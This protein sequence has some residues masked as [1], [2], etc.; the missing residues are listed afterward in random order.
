[1][2]SANTDIEIKLEEVRCA[3]CGQNK[4]ELI[5]K[6]YDYE[7]R[8]SDREFCFVRCLN[9]GHHYLNPR[10]VREAAGRIYPANYYTME[11][12]HSSKSKIIAN[13]KSFVIE[14]R[15]SHFK[16][17]F[18]RAINVLEVGCGDCSLIIALKKKFPHINCAGIDLKFP[19][20]ERFACK[21][22]GITLTEGA[23][24]DV[25][26][27]PGSYNLVILN[28][29]I[30]H[31]WQPVEVLQKLNKSMAQDGL[32]SIETVNFS[33]YDRLFFKKGFWGG[34]YFPRHLNL[35][36]FGTLETLLENA[37]FDVI[38]QNSLLAPVVWTFSFH[39]WV[40]HFKNKG[41]KLLAGFFK[42]SNPVCLG[43]FSCLDLMAL[44]CG[45]TTSNQ[46]TIGRKV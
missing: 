22:L 43:I 39:A 6:G 45:L 3:I 34:Y 25:E 19:K 5:S 29:L 14:K 27:A 28:Q 35:F 9:C 31:L 41:A 20:E 40:S 42:D 38:K 36:N 30:E 16:G 37:G 26:L 46:K 4:A 11:G 10:P 21:E 8:S 17:L 2:I 44:L 24:E 7:Y 13:L 23:I 1:M 32:I 12:R 18:N 33:G 15:L